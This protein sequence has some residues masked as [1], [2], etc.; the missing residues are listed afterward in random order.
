[1]AW[2]GL[3]LGLLL[4][5]PGRAAAAEL[6]DAEALYTQGKMLAAAQIARSIGGAEALTLA[7][8]ATLVAALYLA[9]EADQAKLLQRAAK[10][11]R[12][13]LALDP[14]DE[15]ALLQLALALGQ[16][17]ERAGPITAH[18]EGYAKE[19]GL[20]PTKL[21]DAIANDNESNFCDGTTTYGPG[22]MGT[23]GA[24]N[25]RCTMLPP[26]GSCDD[27][28]T[29]RA[30]VKPA[31]GQLVITEIMPN[32]KVEPGQEW[33]EI[34]N[35]G[36]TTFDLNGLGLDR[37]NDTRA[38]D[39]VASAACKSVRPGGFALLA[40][41]ADPSTNGGLPPVDATFGFAMINANGEVQVVDPASCATVSPYAC[42][43]VY[44]SVPWTTTS[45]GVSAQLKPG[46]F[47]V[48][49]NDAPANFCP[50]ITGYGT[51]GN[52]G[53]PRAANACN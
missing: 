27:G 38:P 39:V 9:P 8:K 25:A 20:D 17:A 31:A 26:P 48:T 44:D 2:L 46:M 13:A 1:M 18:L 7:A 42:T 43:V 30:I 16:T 5:V 24:M 11:A 49:D 29:I 6:A 40:H 22:G 37:A 52:K 36:L 14:D 50:A 35:T 32:P 4:T 19:L 28:G 34:A 10:D 3:V 21:M 33:F 53:T 41:S 45:D 23:P 47:T 51:G 15:A 12:K